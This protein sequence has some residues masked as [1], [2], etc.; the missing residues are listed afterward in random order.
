MP[1]SRPIPSTRPLRRRPN[2]GK[3]SAALPKDFVWGAAAAAYQIEGGWNQG[4]RGPSIWDH[5][6]QT[7]GKV[8]E[9]HTGNVACD[10]YHRWREDVR[11]MRRLGL[12]AY[13]LSVS[14]SRIL[15]RGIGRVNA[16]GLDFYD[17]LVDALLA[18][19]IRPWVTLYHWD[20]PLA[21]QERGGF[22]NR[23]IVE[24]FGDYTEIVVRRLGDRVRHWITLNEPPVIVGLGM[25]QGVFAPGQTLSFA[26]CLKAAHHLLLAHGRSVQAI[27]A[28]SPGPAR[29]S[30]AHTGRE[31]I[32]A[33]RSIKDREAARA[34]T[35]RC[36]ERGFDNVAWWADPMILGRYP[37]DGVKAFAADLPSIRT[38]D[39]ALISQPIDFLAYNCY[40]GF[41]VRAG[42]RGEAERVPG[43]WGPGNPRGTLP[44]LQVAPEAPYWAA[45]FL[46]ERYQL[47]VVFTENGVC[48]TDF[49]HLD[50]KVHDPQRI[51]FL[52]RY[53]GGMARAVR[54][55]IP[56]E[57]YFYWSILDNFEWA[58]G[59]K[60]RFGLIHVDYGTQK[61]TPKDSFTWYRDLIR[62]RGAGL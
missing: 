31:R 47:P 33:S 6:S 60:D 62:R 8:F 49:V 13:R 51:D 18:A 46:H 44:W 53:L 23:E 26:K 19:G 32:P 45:R 52:Q 40:S 20:L 39:L 43:G 29:V 38:G 37:E 42:A 5:F 10:H 28:T 55:G 1:P 30:L 4:G 15:P 25:Q 48:T 41:P 27:R 16:R 35:F 24:W 50:G 7:P 2:R 3:T 61:R 12:D 14:W 9:D 17:R 59:Y 58:Q 34:D 11:W 56:V 21:L 57:G 36:T 54:E 22:Q